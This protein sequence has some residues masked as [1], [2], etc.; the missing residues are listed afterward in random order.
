MTEQPKPGTAGR[1]IK[2][3]L[4]ADYSDEFTPEQWAAIVRATE[5]FQDTTG[6]E[7]VSGEPW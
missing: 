4:P 3:P 2:A 6:S 5:Q 1:G 7:I